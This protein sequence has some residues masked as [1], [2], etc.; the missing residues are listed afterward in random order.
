[1]DLIFLLNPPHGVTGVDLIKILNPP[2]PF[3]K[4]SKSKTK[5]NFLFLS[6]KTFE[7]MM[8]N[9]I[10]AISYFFDETCTKTRTF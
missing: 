2:L 1:V 8:K 4:K 7:G 10:I 3:V 6:Y 9:F 5:K